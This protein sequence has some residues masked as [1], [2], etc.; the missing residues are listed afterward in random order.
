M[1][2]LSVSQPQHS[3][4]SQFSLP[5]SQ[6][7]H[8]SSLYTQPVHQMAPHTI[9]LHPPPVA[10]QVMPHHLHR[11]PVATQIIGPPYIEQPQYLTAIPVQQ[12]PTT[13]LSPIQPVAEYVHS[14]VVL[15]PAPP[16][17][18]TEDHLQRKSEELQKLIVQ[19][20]DELRRVSEQLFMARYGII[21]SIVNVSV[22]YVAP[23]DHADLGES[24][25]CISTSSH[26]SYHELH[27]QNP[28]MI[29]HTQI[30][31]QHQTNPQ[32]HAQLH[33]HLNQTVMP[34]PPHIPV[35]YDI[36]PPKPNL[37]EQQSIEA[38]QQNE[39]IM[40][41]MQHQSQSHSIQPQQQQ[42]IHSNDF[43]LM[44]FQMMNQQANILF[45]S[46]NNNESNSANNK[47]IESKFTCQ[48]FQ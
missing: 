8:S 21:P 17:N 2:K 31:S 6:A 47:W 44:P 18:Q 12:Y 42:A 25:R 29:Q 35:Q 1:S 3:H 39:D 38:D 16:Q 24:S 48:N 33:S 30:S 37:T 26:A 40:H 28:Q 11:P 5:H 27:P 23:I 19:Q 45:S 13:M 20:Q 9:T 7:S 36:N 15:A 34:H 22:P 46:G 32:M 41:Y 14:S 10:T 43:E 4:F